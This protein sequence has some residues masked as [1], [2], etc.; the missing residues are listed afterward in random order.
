MALYDEQ[1]AGPVVYT[2][3]A[4]DGRVNGTTAGITAR[5]RGQSPQT[6]QATYFQ[7]SAG[8]KGYGDMVGACCGVAQLY[9]RNATPPKFADEY[10]QW[11]GISEVTFFPVVGQ[12]AQIQYLGAMTQ[13]QTVKPYPGMGSDYTGARPTTAQMI[14][15]MNQPAQPIGSS[16]NQIVQLLLGAG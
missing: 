15:N 5:D 8:D 2:Q 4:G 3:A 6:V 9:P 13:L 12:E 10:E 16:D 7:P 14:A 1:C 11:P